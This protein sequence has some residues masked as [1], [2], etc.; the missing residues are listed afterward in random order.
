MLSPQSEET[1]ERQCK[2]EDR[3]S[4]NH[5]HDDSALLDDLECA[6][7]KERLL[8]TH[9]RRVENKNERND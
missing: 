4:Q 1:L 5:P 2:S 3:T 8:R 9:G 6:S 7:A